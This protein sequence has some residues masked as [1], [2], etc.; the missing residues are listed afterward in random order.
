MQRVARDLPVLL[1]LSASSP[2]WNEQDTGY[3]SIRTITWQRWPTA[4]ATGPLSS[5]QAYDEMLADLIRT[6]VI[7]DAKMA[8]FDVRPSAH[9]PTLELRTCDA[10]P[11]VDDAVLIGGLFRAAVLAAEQ[12]I[13]AG[14]PFDPVPLPV[15]RA[16]IWQAAR[17]G[18]SGVLL[19]DSRHPRPRPAAKVVRSLLRRLRPQ[20]E[21]LGDWAEVRELTKTVL[22]R[23]N[24]ADRQRAAYAERGRLSDVVELVVGETQGPPG[25][26]QPAVPALRRYR[27]RAGD[28]AVGPQH[29]APPDLLRAA[30]STSASSGITSCTPEKHAAVRWVDSAEM[31]FGV[32]GEKRRFSVDLMPRVINLHEW[33]TL[34]QGLIQR[35]RTIEAF[36]RDVYGEQRIIADG[37]LSRELVQESPGWR[38]EARRLP[39]GHGPSRGDGLRPGAQRVRRLA[40][41]GGQRPQP[42]RRRVRHRHP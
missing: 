35:A 3:A 25:G 14:R 15:H 30:S 38:P 33:R 42:E 1:A 8:Y 21:K 34:G 40:G 41:A 32:G 20:L 31:T 11:I 27:Y 19:D 18:L 17:G 4:G 5:A 24:S 26:P 13:H 10:C 6:G 28:E 12:E 36:L 9:T 7:A 23:G 37:V 39:T 29:A 22:A 2:Y 16:A